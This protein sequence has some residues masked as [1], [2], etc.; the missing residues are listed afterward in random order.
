MWWPQT[1]VGLSVYI[2]VA[3]KVC[4]CV[5]AQLQ[6]YDTVVAMQ[7]FSTVLSISQNMSQSLIQIYA[8][9]ADS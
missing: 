4:V 8:L 6:W 3:C 5:K 7:D 2:G 1:P 9:Q